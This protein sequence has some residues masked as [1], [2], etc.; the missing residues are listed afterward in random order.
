MSTEFELLLRQWV[1]AASAEWGYLQPTDEYLSS[2]TQRIPPGVRRLVTAGHDDALIYPVGDYRFTLQGLPA[3]K[4]PYAWVG[5]N[6]SAGAP[7]M[8]WE[9]LV[10]AAEYARIYRTVSARGY[11]IAVEDRLMDITISDT[12]GRLRWDLE[13]KEKAADVPRFVDD[14]RRY[15]ASGVDLNAPD[16]GNDAL[17]K[18]KYIVRYRP[19]YF[20]VSA[21]GIRMDFAVTLDG[22]RFSLAEDMVPFA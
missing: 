18:A 5:R 12:S 3:G 10:Q 19:E 8:H 1:H 14:I 2:I 17:R 6:P 22:N 4:G 21:I 13:V 16:R 20:S 15:G 7:A 9:Y 11:L